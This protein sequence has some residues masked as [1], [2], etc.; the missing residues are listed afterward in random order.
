M[1]LGQTPANVNFDY[2]TGLLR[3]AYHKKLNSKVGLKGIKK[4]MCFAVVALAFLLDGATGTIIT[5]YAMLL[6]FSL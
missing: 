6:Y 2:V 4:V 3:A 1:R 5:S